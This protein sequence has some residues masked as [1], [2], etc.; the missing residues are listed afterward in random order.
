MCVGQVFAAA[1]QN[2]QFYHHHHPPSNQRNATIIGNPYFTRIHKY[3]L[4]L[5][6]VSRGPAN[7]GNNGNNNK[8]ATKLLGNGGFYLFPLFHSVLFWVYFFCER[9]LTSTKTVARY[10][11]MANVKVQNM[12]IYTG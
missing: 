10:R 12:K 3:E 11:Y 8:S 9:E 4:T 5:S 7:E 2:T 1:P 6:I